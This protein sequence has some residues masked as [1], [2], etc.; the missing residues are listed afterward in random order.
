MTCEPALP[1]E[2]IPKVT[3]ASGFVFS[4]FVWSE[5]FEINSRR[6]GTQDLE[7]EELLEC[8]PHVNRSPYMA[9]CHGRRTNIAVTKSLT[10][11]EIAK[12]PEVQAAI[13]K[14]ADGLLALKTWD[15]D[16]HTN[17]DDLI[18]DAV[19]KGIKIIIGD[20]LIL[21]SIKFFECASILEIQGTL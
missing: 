14:E 1:D 21:G 4:P 12:C 2:H 6:R 17:K 3:Q 8:S 5:I 7:R 13:K 9:D 18:K 20:L 15:Q 19:R 10:R 11:E 16:S